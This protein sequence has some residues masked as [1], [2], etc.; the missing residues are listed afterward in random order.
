MKLPKKLIEERDKLNLKH[1]EALRYFENTSF[2][3]V[4]KN[5]FNAGAQAVLKEAQ[6]LVEALKFY[7]RFFENE[8]G[9]VEESDFWFVANEALKKWKEGMGDE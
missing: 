2:D 1:N 6:G 7:P 5:G 9:E 4:Y 8:Y 3:Q